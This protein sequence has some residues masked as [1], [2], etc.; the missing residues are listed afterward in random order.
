MTRPL[1]PR[2]LEQLSAYL[3]QQL[4]SNERQKLEARLQ[5]ET[6]LFQTLQDLRQTRALLRSLPRRRA[7]R[8]YTLSAQTAAQIRRPQRLPFWQQAPAWGFA[9]ALAGLLLVAFFFGELLGVFTPALPQTAVLEAPAL[10]EAFKQADQAARTTTEEAPATLM[11]E[12]MPVEGE[13]N[14]AGGMGG[15]GSDGP[16]ESFPPTETPAYLELEADRRASPTPEAQALMLPAGTPAAGEL[17][18]AATPAVDTQVTTP[19][20]QA[21]VYPWVRWIEFSLLILGLSAGFAAW[22][23]ARRSRGR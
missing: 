15:G 4:S 19:E 2:D 6:L 9:S 18:S 10:A 13:A 20:P 21:A 7:P 23:L 22:Q 1:S 14:G 12:S 3:D 17:E 11:Q 5:R 8:N 16:V